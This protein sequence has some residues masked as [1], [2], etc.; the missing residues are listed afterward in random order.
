MF[1]IDKSVWPN[2]RSS[3]SSD[4]WT[5]NLTPLKQL[6]HGW[7]NP[8]RRL[9]CATSR[10]ASQFQHLFPH[11]PFASSQGLFPGHWLWPSPLC[12]LAQ[13]RKHLWRCENDA[14]RPACSWMLHHCEI[15]I[16]HT[17]RIPT[18]PVCTQLPNWIWDAEES[19]HLIETGLQLQADTGS[20]SSSAS[21]STEKLPHR[22]YFLVWGH[23]EQAR[24]MRLHYTYRAI[25]ASSWSGK[26]TSGGGQAGQSALY[27]GG[28][29]SGGSSWYREYV[30]TR[31]ILGGHGATRVRHQLPWC[32][33]HWEFC[34]GCDSAG[35][36][37][38]QEGH[39]L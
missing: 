4:S 25:H 7:Y 36:V 31:W 24:I 18:I 10:M 11:L 23:G 21:H 3:G 1:L 16:E 9:F 20:F 27:G 39:N 35:G 6:S 28:W 22:T 14:R 2:E 37:A 32:W 26:S 12:Q 5:R 33:H 13:V 29:A 8:A 19:F 34:I 17:H 15:Y 38:C 30:E